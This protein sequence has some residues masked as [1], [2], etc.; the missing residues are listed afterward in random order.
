MQEVG[1]V[2][3]TTRTGTIYHD[4]SVCVNINS[5]Y[6]LISIFYAGTAGTPKVA[7]KIAHDNQNPTDA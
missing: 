3:G 7:F 5:C 6:Y 1:T 4:P 2:N